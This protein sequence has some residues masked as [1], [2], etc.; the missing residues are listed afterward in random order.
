MNQNLEDWDADSVDGKAPEIG[1]DSR[2]LINVSTG[3][4][5]IM[6]KHLLPAYEESF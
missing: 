2:I 6:C 5:Y 4:Q 3:M 1:K